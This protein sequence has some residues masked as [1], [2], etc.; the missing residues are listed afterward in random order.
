[1]NQHNRS[2]GRHKPGHSR[3]SGSRHPRRTDQHD[4]Q[5]TDQG[6]RRT[7]H[8]HPRSTDQGH[9]RR[10]D[11]GHPRRTDQGHPRRTDQGHPRRT[12]QGHPRH[13]DQGHPRRTDQGHPRNT[14]QDQRRSANQRQSG[15]RNEHPRGVQQRSP[16]DRTHRPHNRPT[17]QL[18]R[19]PPRHIQQPG[20]GPSTVPGPEQESTGVLE[21]IQSGAGFLRQLNE[22][23]QPSQ[24]DVFVPPSIIQQKRLQQG[25]LLK[26]MA[27]YS[28]SRG[29]S[30]AVTKLLEINGKPADDYQE[31]TPFERQVS[32]DPQE[33]FIL[34]PAQNPQSDRSLR[35]L[36]LMTPIGKG[37]RALIVAPPRTG[38]TTLLHDLATSIEEHHPE[39]FLVVLLVD[40]RP[41]EVTHF[42]R[43]VRGAVIASSSDQDAVTHL[44]VARLTLD[45]AR[46]QAE[47]GRDVFLLLDSITRLGRASN[48]QEQNRGKTLS[49]GVG[50]RAL[51]FPRRFFGSARNLEGGGSLTIVATALIDTGSRMD[52]VIFQ[53]FKGTGNMELV[54]DRKLADS[55]LFPAVDLSQSGTRK[56]EKILPPE[57]LNASHKLRRH[58]SNL[59]PK[60]ALDVLM[61]RLSKA[62]SVQAFC[63]TIL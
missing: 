48:R 1:M 28:P 42:K 61:E 62:E 52:E 51:E 32:I 46:S 34:T 3:T 47:S 49:G 25:M 39:T 9:P 59:P 55:R 29:Q 58:L 23:L 15:Q 36:E 60:D 13:T 57:W 53:E 37:Q 18:H 27:A 22:D 43:S 17:H 21:L 20:P 33:R 2:Q 16:G 31:S 24:G 5:R 38:K 63:D 26:V 50:S 14:D 7:D 40:E 6:P 8:G 41:E 44:R 19:R 10:T 4:H 11:Q 30:A 35:L 12:D 54:L 56:E 45:L